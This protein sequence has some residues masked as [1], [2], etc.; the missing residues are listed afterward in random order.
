[1]LRGTVIR[2]RCALAGILFCGTS[3]A[4]EERP[5]VA[6]SG[7]DA[8]CPPPDYVDERV[9]RLLRSNE[10]G[11][12]AARVVVT[13]SENGYDAVVSVQT[14]EGRGERR[15]SATTC[16]LAADAAAVIVAISIFPERAAELAARAE[17][18]DDGASAA[19]RSVA[20]SLATGGALDTSLPSV[21]LGPEARFDARIGVHLV[22]EIS[23]AA[24]LSQ[25][26]HQTEKYAARF[27][28]LTGALR[29]CYAVGLGRVEGAPCVG[30][31]A[32]RL[33]GQGEGTDV[34]YDGVGL[35]VGPSAGGMLRWKLSSSLGL[36][37]GAEAFVPLGRRPF[38]LNGL[39]IHRPPAIG[40]AAFLGPEVSF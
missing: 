36:R 27:D 23:A 28:M 6:F 4:N 26:V 13:K 9:G 11:Q 7:P 32:V 2:R 30:V 33:A 39:E 24:F 15:F 8:E 1:M 29:G 21:A 31:K 18:A 40:G 14:K 16:E 35:Y 12:G 3:L 38:L 5:P 17:E 22:L 34:T 10:R 20:F 25:V 19:P 37:L